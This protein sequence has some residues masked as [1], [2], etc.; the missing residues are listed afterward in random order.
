MIKK[1][2]I[3]VFSTTRSPQFQRIKLLK[4]KLHS[5]DCSI[6][7]KSPL[8][9]IV[10]YLKLYVDIISTCLYIISNKAGFLFIFVFLL[11]V[12]PFYAVFLNSSKPKM[13]QQQCY[14]LKTCG[15]LLTEPK[16]GLR[17]F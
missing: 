15:I 16:E 17:T 1:I 8:P 2:C 6:K 10:S 4:G 3:I 13:F 12:V 9:L 14:V 7:V 5:V 11:N